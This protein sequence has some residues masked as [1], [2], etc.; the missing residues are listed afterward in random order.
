MRLAWDTRWHPQPPS[1]EHDEGCGSVQVDA[2]GL[3]QSWG[4]EGAANLH[5]GPLLCGGGALRGPRRLC[6]EPLQVWGSMCSIHTHTP[7]LE[8]STAQPT[9]H[10]TLSVGVSMETAPG[11]S[12]CTRPLLGSRYLLADLAWWGWG[13][14]PD[15]DPLPLILLFLIPAATLFRA[16]V[17]SPSPD[18]GPSWGR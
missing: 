11:P 9:C 8:P 2:G 14:T 18:L 10:C 15:G 3:A 5:P 17:F 16:Q 6:T 1:P 4:W 12:P 13:V 7:L